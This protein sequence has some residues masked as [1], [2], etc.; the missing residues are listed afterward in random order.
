MKGRARASWKL[1]PPQWAG[2]MVMT[3][4]VTAC[5]PQGMRLPQSQFLAAVE[6]KS[7]LIAY[8]GADGNIYTVD[9]GGGEPTPVTTDAHSD[10]SGYRVYDVPAW[11][12]DSLSLAFKAYSG[13]QGEQPS[14]ISLFTAQKDGSQLVQ[15]HT[16]ENNLVY[17]YW[18]PDSRRVAFL[19]ATPGQTLA[20]NLVAPDGGEAET[21]DVGRPYYWTWAP[22]S[23]SL[24]VH[25]GGASP[26]PQAHL[27]LLQIES[28]VT[29]QSLSIK[30][31]EFKAP[32][33]SPD[34]SQAL[35][36]GET[37]EGNTALLLTDALGG[38]PQTLVEYSG[39]IAFAW[40]PDGK[41][42]AYVVTPSPR[43]GETG[44]LTVVDP[45]EKK[46]P[47]ELK[48]QEVY[49]FFW[50]PD[51]KSLA[52][53]TG[54]LVR[55]EAATPEAGTPEASGA[56][57]S[58][59]TFVWRLSVM[60]ASSGGSRTVV[61][62]F[63]PTEQFLQVLPYFDQYH[64]STTIW[65]PDSENLVISAYRGDGSPGIWIAAA[66]GNLEPRFIADGWVGF[67]SWK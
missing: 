42:I 51:S 6:R 13:L 65:S 64:Q 43:I 19:S 17:Y 11:S 38:A 54:E 24:L 56:T 46:K 66:S 61:S 5:L 10:D 16:G 32:A 18:S 27:S 25:V 1:A 21:V 50:S 23:R 15:A 4:L 8:L 48:D 53:F 59:E 35:V 20:L 33:Y 37:A 67:W 12:P 22:D 30:P 7:G 28:G 47:V 2:V 34:G 39:N 44:T 55:N 14:S 41:R 62:G 52:Y 9:Q 36:A 60:E 26:A 29:E 45:T 63:R 40:S 57:G 58:N 3:L 49:G 31:S